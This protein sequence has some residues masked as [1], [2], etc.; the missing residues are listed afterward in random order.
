M[1][2]CWHEN[3]LRRPT[4]MELR[5][6]LEGIMSQRQIYI[7]FDSDEDSVPSE[8]EEDGFNAVVTTNTSISPDATVHRRY[9]EPKSV[10]KS[11][12]VTS[13]Q[14]SEVNFLN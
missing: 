13:S 12:E 8:H 4:F 11:T 6:E 3:P 14:I 10:A 9:I 1:L 5:E 2:R 7:S